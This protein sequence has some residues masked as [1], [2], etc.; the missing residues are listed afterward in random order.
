MTSGRYREER[1]GKMMPGDAEFG[2]RHTLPLVVKM[3]G[4]RNL[5]AEDYKSKVLLVIRT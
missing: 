1:K 2:S 4:R 5:V 3:R